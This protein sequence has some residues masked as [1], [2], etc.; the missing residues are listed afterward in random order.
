MKKILPDSIFLHCDYTPSFMGTAPEPLDKNL[1]ELS[2][3]TKESSDVDA[4]LDTDG[5]ADR[6]AMYDEKGK[7]V[8]AHH[9]I[10][11]LVHYLHKYRQMRGKVVIAFSVS[12]K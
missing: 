5:D 11:L 7:Y 10:L 6:I 9:L 8:D 12:N 2:K 4:G 1:Q 3:L